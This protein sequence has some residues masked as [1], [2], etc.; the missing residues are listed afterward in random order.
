MSFTASSLM[1]SRRR[2]KCNNI[3]TMV[4]DTLQFAKN[5]P[6]QDGTLAKRLGKD[7][8]AL[9]YHESITLHPRIAE[10][11]TPSFR[12]PHPYSDSCML[13]CQFSPLVHKSSRN[14]VTQR[15]SQ[16]H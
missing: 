4:F 13:D 3:H 1:T 16:N 8:F 5:D 12:V 6:H 15:K 11:D 10:T 14:I 7:F 9:R 2:R